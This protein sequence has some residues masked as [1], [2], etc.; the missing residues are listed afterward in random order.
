MCHFKKN[1]FEEA[2]KVLET[3]PAPERAGDLG[4]APYLLAECQIRLAPAKAEDALQIGML[5]ERL[6]AA[7]R[8]TWRAS[9]RRQSR[10]P[11]RPPTPC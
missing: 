5:Q 10:R 4:H 3:I 11:R 9:S 6:Q 7:I 2:Q 8:K 1:D